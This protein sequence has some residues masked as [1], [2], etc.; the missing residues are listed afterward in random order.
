MK[1]SKNTI[2]ITGGIT[3]TGLELARL[4]SA[5]GNKVIITGKNK[6]ELHRI[7]RIHKN[8]DIL[9]CDLACEE[10]IEKMIAKIHDKFP[11]INVF[12]NNSG[13]SYLESEEHLVSQ[14]PDKL[15]S[16][17]LAGI[18]VTEELLPLFEKQKKATIIDASLLTMDFLQHTKIFTVIQ[19]ITGSYNRLLRHKLR[20]TKIEV[21]D[22]QSYLSFN[23]NSSPVMVAL[24]LIE[25]IYNKNADPP[26]FP[27]DY[28]LINTAGLSRNFLNDSITN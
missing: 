28:A 26:P 14:C 22:L 15:L 5:L 9:T 27:D 19:N 8:I 4:L 25:A 24:R 23:Q 21:P 16:Q 12:I 18:R 2:L 10:E 1:T 17:Y 13:Q 6:I 7:S 3:G 20:N 11:D